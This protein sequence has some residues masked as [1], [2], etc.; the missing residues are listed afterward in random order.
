MLQE[1]IARGITADRVFG[2]SVGAINGASYAGQ[3]TEEKRRRMAPP[4]GA[5]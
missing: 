2:A 3:P 1:L 4:S 5:P